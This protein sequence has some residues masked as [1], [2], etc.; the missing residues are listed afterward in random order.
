MEMRGAHKNE[1]G[2]APSPAGFGGGSHKAEHLAQPHEA[3]GHGDQRPAQ[4]TPPSFSIGQ[5]L[6]RGRDDDKRGPGAYMSI[7]EQSQG[8][9]YSFR[10][11]EREAKDDGPGPGEYHSGVGY[12]AI[13]TSSPAYSMGAR[14]G[15]S[16]FGTA[17]GPGAAYD[18]DKHRGGAGGGGGASAY[19]VG[20]K[21]GV[22]FSRGPGPGTYNADL[23]SGSPSFSIGTRIRSSDDRSDSPGPG[24]YEVY[25]KASGPSYSMA[26][27]VKAQITQRDLNP[28]PGAYTDDNT[29]SQTRGLAFTMRERFR[30]S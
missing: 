14:C 1:T 15:P 9:A 13:K 23:K 10:K 5:R 24:A 28:G 17:A 26:S 2:R 8:P 29:T 22:G 12:R 21:A 30:H 25:R 7:W 16:A 11:K 4:P 6:R 18:A 19:T 27:K 20:Y 3:L